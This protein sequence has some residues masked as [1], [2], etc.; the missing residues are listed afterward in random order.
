MC[1]N[2]VE[3]DLDT[4]LHEIISLSVALC[5]LLWWLHNCACFHAYSSLMFQLLYKHILQLSAGICIYALHLVT[6]SPDL[7]RTHLVPVGQPML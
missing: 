6:N 4:L 1:H 5:E 2:T 7:C 3:M